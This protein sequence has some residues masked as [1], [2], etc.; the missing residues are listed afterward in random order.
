M[1]RVIGDTISEFWS[2]LTGAF[3]AAWPW[4]LV[5]VGLTSIAVL[6]HG[7]VGARW[8]F[9]LALVGGAAWAIH[10]WLWYYF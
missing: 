8:L 4:L 5:L 1:S 6:F 7:R 10:R 2:F 3:G 9:P